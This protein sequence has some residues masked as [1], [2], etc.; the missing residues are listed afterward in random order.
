MLPLQDHKHCISV[1]S[2][3]TRSSRKYA[4]LARS[5]TLHFGWVCCC[6]RYEFV[7][8][9]EFGSKPGFGVQS[10][11]WFW[12]WLTVWTEY[13]FYFGSE[14]GFWVCT[15]VWILNLGLGLRLGLTLGFGFGFR[16]WAGLQFWFNSRFGFGSMF[17]FWVWL[18]FEF[19]PWAGLEF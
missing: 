9:Y 10:V 5:Q 17:G 16:P 13:G 8:G 4:S 19:G 12:I 15:Y 2:A 6:Y 3:S 11:S 14:C 18:G 7:S 1:G